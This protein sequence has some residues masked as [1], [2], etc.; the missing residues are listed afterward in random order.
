MGQG[1]NSDHSTPTTASLTR[2]TCADT[3]HGRYNEP[4]HS[5]VSPSKVIRV[6]SGILADTI[7][8]APLRLAFTMQ[9]V[10]VRDENSSRISIDIGTRVPHRCSIG[11][12][13][14]QLR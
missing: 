2:V 6:C 14:L 5:L 9:P 3:R 4:P 8:S 11:I 10:E 7:T 13:S 1:A 12:P